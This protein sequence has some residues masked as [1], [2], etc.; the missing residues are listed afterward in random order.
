MII[1]DEAYRWMSPEARE[2]CLAQLRKCLRPGERFIMQ[3]EIDA[4]NEAR[5]QAKLAERRARRAARL[6]V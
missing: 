4:E 1:D 3:S 2:K 6:R 5:Y